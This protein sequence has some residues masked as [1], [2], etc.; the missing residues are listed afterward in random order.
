MQPSFKLDSALSRGLLDV[1]IKAGLV[2]ALVIFA[3]Q[4]FQPFLELM[5]WAVILAVTLFPLHCRLQRRTGLKQGYAATLVVVL[6]LVVLLVPIYLVV[7]SIGESVDSL[8]TLLK[9]GAWSVPTPPDAVAAWPLIGPK[10]HALWLAASENMASVLNQWMPQIKG[11]GV[12]VLGAAA[13][14]GAAFLLF[15]GAI[16]ISGVIMA[17][18]DRGEVAAQRIAMRVSGEERG[19]PLAKLCTATIRAVA[20][21]VIGIAFIQMLLIGV[22]FVVKGVPGAGMLAIVILMLGIAQAPATLVTVPVIIY[23]FNVEGFTAATIVFAIY[24]FVAGLADNV[25]KPLL[26]GRG[27]DVPM[28]VVLIGALGGM[29]V[30]GIIGLFI[31]P[32]I[33]GVTYVLFWQWVALQVPENPVQPA[34]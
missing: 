12:T 3:F 29:V 26:L 33:L 13:S 24:T 17:F 6:V 16:I 5:L 30:K 22:G 11:A 9:S 27:V 31:G 34:A 7:M 14:A 21:G 4:V 18:G 28:P 8:V 1:L 2:A 23:V 10:V 20:Q 25:L 19:K 15:I 32:V